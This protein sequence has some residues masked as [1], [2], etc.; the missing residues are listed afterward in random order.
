MIYC[1]AFYELLLSNDIRYFTGVPDSMLKD[2]CAYIE[3]HSDPRDNII[4]ANEGNAIALASGRYLATNRIG[5]VY[6]QNSGLGNSINP[7]TSLADPEIYSIPMLLLIGWRGEPG[8]KDEPQHTKQGKI[9]LRLLETLEIP[10]EVLPDNNDDIKFVI[11]KAVKSLKS[12]CSP[13]ALVVKKG[14]FDSYISKRTQKNLYTL[15]REQALELILDRLNADDIIV[16]STGKLSRELFELR[17]KNHHVHCQDFLTVGS[18]GH[19]SQI[20]LGIAI[21]KREQKVYCLDGDGAILM[22]MGSLAISGIHGPENFKHIVFNNGVHNSVGNQ[23]T[24]GFDV[25]FRSIARS[26]GYNAVYY[27]DNEEEIHEK[28]SDFQSEQ[29]PAF[30]EIRINRDVRENLAR[31]TNTPIIN[32]DI[33]MDFVLKK[34]PLY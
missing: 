8:V 23:P 19:A 24:V 5:L 28:F 13:Y 12:T 20:A 4:T 26:C 33:F 22:H 18:M 16:S 9:T 11:E 10:Y 21:E 34:L 17:E 29:G 7:L 2:I 15:N 3:D 1:K 27:V 31:P 30:L 32:K 25:D 14:T 6:M